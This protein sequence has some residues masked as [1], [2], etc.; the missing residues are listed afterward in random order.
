MPDVMFPAAAMREQRR[1]ADEYR[2]RAKMLEA[3]LIKT[4]IDSAF[5]LCG[6]PDGERTNVPM[7]DIVVDDRGVVHGVGAAIRALCAAVHARARPHP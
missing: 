5:E 4:E 1:R 3:A 7:T 2:R 6:L